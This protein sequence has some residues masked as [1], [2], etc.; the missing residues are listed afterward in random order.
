MRRTRA[1]NR[2]AWTRRRP[3]SHRDPGKEISVQ[4]DPHYH[5][6]HGYVYV[7]EYAFTLEELWTGVDRLERRGVSLAAIGRALDQDLETSAIALARLGRRWPCS[8]PYRVRL[9]LRQR[10]STNSG[11]RRTLRPICRPSSGNM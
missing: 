5:S 7:N 6:P 11:L 10:A 4:D 3:G 8:R 9:L 2:P 1:E